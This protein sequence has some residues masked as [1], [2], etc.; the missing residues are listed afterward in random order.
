MCRFLNADVYFDTHSGS[1]LSTNMF[2]YCENDCINNVDSTGYTFYRYSYY[3]VGAQSKYLV[4]VTFYY[5]CFSVT[6]NFT[7]DKGI[8]KLSL[9]NE[10]KKNNKYIYNIVNN[11]YRFTTL[12]CIGDTYALA[13]AIYTITKRI[14]SKY[15]RGRTI[16][17]INSELIIHYACYVLGIKRRSTH[18]IDIGSSLGAVGY[19]G[20]A[21]V[22]ETVHFASLAW[23]AIAFGPGCIS[24]YFLKNLRYL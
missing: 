9:A 2:T 22:F 20:N 12:F 18:Q 10:Y 17:G 15:L 19:D 6:I 5:W 1:P 24:S 16:G 4:T 23:K 3:R 11:Y 8:V 14:S 21:W 13:H 7:V